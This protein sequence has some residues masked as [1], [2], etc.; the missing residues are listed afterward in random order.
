V[1]ELPGIDWVFWRFNWYCT[2][3][4]L[5][6]TMVMIVQETTIADYAIDYPG[7]RWHPAG[8]MAYY[9]QTVAMPQRVTLRGLSYFKYS[10]LAV[11]GAQYGN[12]YRVAAGYLI[13]AGNHIP[14][15]RAGFVYHPDVHCAL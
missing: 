2:A 10:F 9:V 14:P 13:V 4:P 5:F 11:W 12:C 3:R 6:I 8:W 15:F 7:T 1:D